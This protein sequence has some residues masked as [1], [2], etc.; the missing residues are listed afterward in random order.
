MPES[1]DAL[2]A[3]LFAPDLSDR[4]FAAVDRHSRRHVLVKLNIDEAEIRDMRSRGLS[5]E[6]RELATN[7]AITSRYADIACLDSSGHELFDLIA[8]E[9]AKKVGNAQQSSNDVIKRVIAKWRR[10]WNNA[11]RQL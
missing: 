3:K 7:D 9:I 11:T 2:G 6:T 1:V 5:I 10:F 8:N 4:V